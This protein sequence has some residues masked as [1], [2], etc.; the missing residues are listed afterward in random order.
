[1]TTEDRAR[2]LIDRIMMD[3][4]GVNRSLYNVLD[5]LFGDIDADR[6]T[7]DAAVALVKKWLRDGKKYSYQL[8]L[9]ELD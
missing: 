6:E 5:I 3:L 4:N 8:N 1:M 7:V 2:A 9:N